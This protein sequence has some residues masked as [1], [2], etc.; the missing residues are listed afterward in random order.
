MLAGKKRNSANL[1]LVQGEVRSKDKEQVENEP[2][3]DT[4][5][6]KPLFVKKIPLASKIWD[7][8]MRMGLGKKVLT[9]PD[10][11]AFGTLCCLCAEFETHVLTSE[12][13]RKHPLTPSPAWICQY[14]MLCE[15]FGLVPAGRTRIN[16]KKNPKPDAGKKGK[17][18]TE[19][20]FD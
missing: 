7:E 17:G 14:R 1:K 11:R 12:G 15:L 18:K 10:S 3:Y 16:E 4:D 20:Y 19:N 9:E 5:P 8:Y 2:Q 13:G 6:V